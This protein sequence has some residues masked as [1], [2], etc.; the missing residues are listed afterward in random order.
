[1]NRRSVPPARPPLGPIP[2]I[3]DRSDPVNLWNLLRR[4]VREK[5]VQQ[6]VPVQRSLSPLTHIFLFS[7]LSNPVQNGQRGEGQLL[8][9]EKER[10][11]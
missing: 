6:E 8:P 1:M 5:R 9:S 4:D 11:K 3:P 10:I 7:T 2:V